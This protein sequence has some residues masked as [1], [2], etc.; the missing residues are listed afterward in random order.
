M[1][2]DALWLYRHIVPRSMEI[3]HLFFSFSNPEDRRNK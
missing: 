2:A 1:N 3:E